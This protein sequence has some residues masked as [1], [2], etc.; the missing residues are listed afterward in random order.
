MQIRSIRLVEEESGLELK[1]RV[2]VADEGMEIMAG[3]QHICPEVIAKSAILFVYDRP[4][5]RKFHMSNVHG[6]LDIAFFS[7]SKTIISIQRMKPYALGG[8][9]VLYES[10]G[11]AQYVLETPPGF[12]QQFQLKS[13]TTRLILN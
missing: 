11:E 4:A 5:P 10:K 8:P 7:E 12:F 3:Y 1:L 2:R 13:G 6:E 9:E